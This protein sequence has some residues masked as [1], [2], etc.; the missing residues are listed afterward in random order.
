MGRKDCKLPDVQSIEMG[1]SSFFFFLKKINQLPH[2]FEGFFFCIFCLIIF[3]LSVFI[4]ICFYFALFCLRENE[5]RVG[6]KVG[7]VW[8]GLGET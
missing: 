6:S 2:F 3:L 1:F 8:E 7:M 5:I 4:F